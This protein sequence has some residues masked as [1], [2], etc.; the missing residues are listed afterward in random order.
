[1]SWC[2]GDDEAL[3][4]MAPTAW[5]THGRPYDLLTTARRD[6]PAPGHPAP[7]HTSQCRFGLSEDAR[8]R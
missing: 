4:E 8:G 3:G 5:L 1:M 7:C 6:A 2:I